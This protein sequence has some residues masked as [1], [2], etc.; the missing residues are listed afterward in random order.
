MS[1]VARRLAPEPSTERVVLLVRKGAG[2]TLRRGAD[3]VEEGVAGPDADSTWDRLVLER[4][5]VGLADEVLG[6]G[7]D[8]YVEE[9]A[10]LRDRVVEPAPG[11]RRRSRRRP[12]EHPGQRQGPGRPAADPGALPA[13]ARR[14]PARRGGPGARRRTRTSCSNDLKVLFMCGLPGGYPDDLIDVDID[15]LEGPD[16]LR[17]DGVIR[18][19]NADYL[20]RPLRLT[21]DRGVGG[22]RRAARAAQ[23]RAATTPVRSSTG[24]WPS[25]RRPPPRGGCRRPGRPRRRRRG[26]RPGPARQPA[27]RPPRTAAGRCG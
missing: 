19:S 25:W 13:R 11:G 21:P 6:Y 22:D 4:G 9:P 3:R 5:S 23:R 2:H 14:G 12:R 7:A 18:V 8:V 17:A 27:S 1:E 16:G 24:R 20:A 10:E 15:A 26:H